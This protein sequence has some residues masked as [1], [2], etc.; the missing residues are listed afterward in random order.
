MNIVFGMKSNLTLDAWD[1]P[2]L[3]GQEKVNG[4]EFHSSLLFY[5]R[6]KTRKQI[7]SWY[8]DV[9]HLCF[10]QH[11]IV[12]YGDQILLQIRCFERDSDTDL[13]KLLL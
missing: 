4:Y 7:S 6:W 9:E 13:S 1:K 3:E 12:L 8:F 2:M 5:L 11:K 10:I